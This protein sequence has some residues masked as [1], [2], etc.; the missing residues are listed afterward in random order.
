[1]SDTDPEA[2]RPAGQVR[3]LAAVKSGYGERGRPDGASRGGN[4]GLRTQPVRVHPY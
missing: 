4:F 1:M 2:Q 3:V